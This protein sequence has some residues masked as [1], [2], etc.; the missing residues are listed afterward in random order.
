MLS[1]HQPVVIFTEGSYYRDDFATTTF[2]ALGARFDLRRTEAVSPDELLEALADADVVVARRGQFKASVFQSLPR[3][4]GLVKWGAGVETIDIPAATEAGVVVT[5]S[6]GNS[7]AVAESAMCLI[8]AVAK[9]LLVMAQAARDGA[10][11]A[12]DVR[13]HELYEKTLGIVGFGR[14]G[15]HLAHIARGFAMSVLAFDPYVSAGKF[16]EL[17]VR[18]VD[19]PTLMRESDYISINCA[20]TPETRHLIG[21]K[22]ISLM[23]PSGYLVNTARGSV[24]DEPALYR[25]LVDGRIAGAGLDVFE[26]EPLDPSNPLLALPN[27]VATPHSL[28]RTWESTGRTTRMIQDAV[29]AI[30]E[31]RL[32]DTTLNPDVERKGVIP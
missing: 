6:P 15:R 7:F 12:F 19:L 9:N 18:Q 29:L 23:K 24:V 14:I 20:L 32:P 26:V 16:D 10:R 17:G 30:L 28:P 21:E 2:P 31:G 25:A 3:L 5:N 1:E 4:L 8:L 27:V 11:P 22:E 13:G